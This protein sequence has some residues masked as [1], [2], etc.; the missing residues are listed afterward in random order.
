MS[1]MARLRLATV[2]LVLGA[3]AASPE[4]PAA[5]ACPA[6]A[7][8][9]ALMDRLI[10]RFNARD[11]AGWDATFHYPHVLSAP[12]RTA[13]F[14]DPAQQADTIPN[15]VAQGWVRSEWGELEVLQCSPAKAHV[16]ATFVRYR[17][18]GSV[19]STTRSVYAVEEQDGRWGVTMRSLLPG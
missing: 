12:G 5:V 4:P 3:C 14:T 16:S 19:L 2:A 6:A 13:I 17:A 11:T 7:P 9:L 15:L 8:A 18:D 10:A 1:D